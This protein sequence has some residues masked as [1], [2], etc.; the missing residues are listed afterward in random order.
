MTDG[1]AMRRVVAGR[2]GGRGSRPGILRR[3]AGLAVFVVVVAGAVL[4]GQR[5]MDD[6][7]SAPRTDDAEIAADTVLIAAPLAGRI[8]ELAVAENQRVEK[9]DVLFRIDPKPY[10]LALAE[11][12]ATLAA[13]EAELAEA[14]RRSAAETANAGGAEDEIRRAED[15]L[16]LAER[17]V[18]RLAPLADQG[19]ISRQEFDEA[20]TA[21]QNARTSLRQARQAA[22]ASRDLVE[23]TEALEAEADA[24]RAAADLARWEL[25]NTTVRA[26]FAGHVVG[27][28]TAVGRVLVPGAP[29]FTLIDDA[30]WHAVALVRET[31]LAVVRP[32]TPAH[33]TVAIAPGTVLEGTVES[34]GRGIQSKEELDLAGRVPYVDATLDWVRVA[35][36]FPVRVRLSAPPEHLRR[37]GASAMVVFSP[38]DDA[39]PR[40]TPAEEKAPPADAPDAGTAAVAGTAGAPR[41]AR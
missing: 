29:V 32:G 16:A 31:D 23:T 19:Y 22:T 40:E 6:L 37:V 33:V 39:T 3:I 17:T 26:P 36:R 18:E 34:I 15:D 11:A 41:A 27:L 10:R 25:D 21:R 5:V 13:A 1:D 38:A 20:V 24:A 8:T 4:V 35:K 14:R 12:E 30:S 28:D 9:G 7:A 2:K